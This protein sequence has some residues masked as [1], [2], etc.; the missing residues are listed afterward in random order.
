MPL[1]TFLSRLVVESWV[2]PF[3][4]LV[5]CVPEML[6]VTLLSPEIFVML[7]L[8]VSSLVVVVGEV[9]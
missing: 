8:L 7:F 5:N 6:K 1:C 4:I 2:V 9:S 3:L